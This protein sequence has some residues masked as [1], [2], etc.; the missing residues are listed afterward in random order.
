MTLYPASNGCLIITLFARST[1]YAAE[2]NQAFLTFSTF[3]GDQ[4][5]LAYYYSYAPRQESMKPLLGNG[6]DALVK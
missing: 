2:S 6:V 4:T 1:G 3:S 5:R